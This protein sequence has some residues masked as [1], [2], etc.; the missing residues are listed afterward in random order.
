[1]RKETSKNT[2]DHFGHCFYARYDCGFG[3]RSSSRD[4]I[5]RLRFSTRLRLDAPIGAMRPSG[6][7]K[8]NPPGRMHAQTYT[9]LDVSTSLLATA[10][11]RSSNNKLKGLRIAPSDSNAW[12]V[13]VTCKSPISARGYAFSTLFLLKGCHFCHFDIDFLLEGS[14]F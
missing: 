13:R 10:R 1:M 14:H 7:Q 5:T 4:K 8:S 2:W 3:M 11:A 12:P 6:A 9:R